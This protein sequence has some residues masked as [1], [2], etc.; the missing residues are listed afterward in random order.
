[1][2]STSLSTST[3]RAAPTPATLARYVSGDRS[4]R[5]VAH[6]EYL[7]GFSELAAFRSSED[8]RALY[9]RFRYLCAYNLTF[10]ECELGLLEAELVALDEEDKAILLDPKHPDFAHVS[11][12]TTS[13]AHFKST[14]HEDPRAARRMDLVT[15]LRS[16][17]QEYRE[18]HI[19]V[20][21]ER[22]LLTPSGRTSAHVGQPSADPAGSANEMPCPASKFLDPQIGLDHE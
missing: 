9:R 22:K 17:L 13:Y 11:H 5:L 4:K 2:S 10:L 6:A 16:L 18:F 14:A 19:D 20:C 21:E 1:M 15:R 7:H 3:S 12:Y 8:E